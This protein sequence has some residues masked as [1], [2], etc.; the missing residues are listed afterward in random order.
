M[1]FSIIAMLGTTFASNETAIVADLLK[2]GHAPG[3]IFKPFEKTGSPE[4]FHKSEAPALLEKDKK[5]HAGSGPVKIPLHIEQFV[6]FQDSPFSEEE[7]GFMLV[8]EY[9][10]ERVVKQDTEE[11]LIQK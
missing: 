9:W 11:K 6:D 4:V 10:K 2:R 7:N 5:M 3:V 8:D 1:K